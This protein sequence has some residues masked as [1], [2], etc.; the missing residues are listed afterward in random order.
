MLAD[1]RVVYP[2]VYPDGSVVHPEP[3]AEPTAGM[4]PTS[5]S[6]GFDEA[7]FDSATFD[8]APAEATSKYDPDATY[9]MK[10]GVVDGEISASPD[11]KGGVYSYVAA[12]VEEASAAP[13][14]ETVAL[15]AR[16]QTRMTGSGGLSV[17]GFPADL[18]VKRAKRRRSTGTPVGRAI[19]QN[20]A[21]IEETGAV[22]IALLEGAIEELRRKRPNSDEGKAVV[23]NE[24]AD[25]EDLK[26]R[27]EAFLAA[28]SQFSTRAV[29]EPS[30]VSATTFLEKGIANWWTK[31]HSEICDLTLRF[32]LFGAGL[33]LCVL[34]GA[35]GPLSA[36]IPGAM[37]GGKPVVDAIKAWRKSGRS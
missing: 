15:E 23:K 8:S 10:D 30:V 17:D 11:R 20:A 26:R 3:L 16:S 14:P 19:L 18:T 36:L 35:D 7:A 33:G 28:A 32:T 12:T 2:V 9:L 27:V 22:F 21:K 37:F 25:C 1:G 31:D 13:A 4:A 24:I 5:V 29:Q 34:A 6:G